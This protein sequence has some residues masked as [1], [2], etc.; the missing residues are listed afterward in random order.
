MEQEKRRKEK[1]NN[2]IVYIIIILSF[3]LLTAYIFSE[4]NKENDF[5]IEQEEVTETSNEISETE[6]KEDS[7]K[8]LKIEKDEGTLYEKDVADTVKSFLEIYLSSNGDSQKLSEAEKFM[9]EPGY[10]MMMGELSDIKRKYNKRTIKEMDIYG[11][12]FDD[13]HKEVSIKAKVSCEISEG[14]I[15]RTVTET[16]EYIFLLTNSMGE[17]KIGLFSEEID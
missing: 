1:K 4:K 17:W 10:E 11:Y 3:I 13:I 15:E 8:Y 14:E 5:Y 7:D 16:S 6:A 12:S 9:T 2:T